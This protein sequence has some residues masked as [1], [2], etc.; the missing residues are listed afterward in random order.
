MKKLNID[1]IKKIFQD[2]ANDENSF[3]MSKYM[4]NKFAYYG[5]KKPIRVEITKE[6]LNSIKQ[7]EES[8]IYSF[9]WE[10]WNEEEREMQY[11]ALEILAQYF[12]KNI[13]DIQFLEK[14]ILTKS[15]W[16]TVDTLSNFTGKYFK[17]NL[18]KELL[19]NWVESDNIWLN[20]SAIIFQLKYK[21]DLNTELL[22]EII[23]KLKHKKEFFIQKAI[24]WIL[25]EYS[26]TNPEFVLNFVDEQNLQGLA[27][28][29]A[30]RLMKKNV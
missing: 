24:G 29:E 14:L 30:I 13:I 28:R 17:S 21:N 25:R 7:Y 10:L 8:E 9:I 4:K 2:N 15:W 23:S 11:L 18:N 6:F 1:Y 27:K 20:R 12:K 26:K 3:Y 19:N 22:S 5:I 16:D